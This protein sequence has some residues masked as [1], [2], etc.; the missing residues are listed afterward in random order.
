ML[1]NDPE[2]ALVEKTKHDIEDIV[3]EETNGAIF[4]SKC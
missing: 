3:E 1:E 2:N 4:R